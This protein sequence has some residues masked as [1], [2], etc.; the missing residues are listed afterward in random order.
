MAKKAKKLNKPKFNE[1]KLRQ[2]LIIILM[3]LVVAGICAGF[4]YI[5]AVM[6]K[7]NSKNIVKTT[8]L[9]VMVE[10]TKNSSLVIKDVIP[11]TEIG[12][13][14]TNP[15][16]FTLKNTG[17]KPVNYSLSLVSDEEAIN[18]C[19]NESKDK[20]CLVVTPDVLRY[21]LKKNGNIL[22]TGLLRDNAG[23]I[24][25]GNITNSGDN[26]VSYELK[27]WVDYE[28]NENTEGAQFFGKLDV[29]AQISK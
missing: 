21:S 3:T 17:S 13:L 24:D 8:S 9:E 4:T 19:K 15:Y 6:S 20:T 7:D 27:I 23:V 16:H 1:M 5:W 28:T 11:M 18:K 2:I 25:M 10:D 14:S 22:S 26:K 12:G 29:K